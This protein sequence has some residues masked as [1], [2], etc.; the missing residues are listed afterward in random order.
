[1]N[2]KIIGMF[3]CML[4][5]ANVTAVLGAPEEK[6]TSIAKTASFVFVNPFSYEDMKYIISDTNIESG[7]PRENAGGTYDN[8]VPNPSFEEGDTMPTGWN[9]TDDPNYD[10]TH[11]WDSS[12]AHSGSKSLG[13]SIDNWYASEEW[14]TTDYI[15]V[16][17]INHTYEL[18]TWVKFLKEPPESQSA[19][20][21]LRLYDANKTGENPYFYFRMSYTNEWKFG[22][23]DTSWI[24][25]M[26]SFLQ[27]YTKYIKIG[28]CQ[29]YEN[30]GNGFDSSV[31]VRFDDVFFGYFEKNSPPTKPTK[32]SGKTEGKTGTNYD[33]S[34]SA[35]DPDN[36]LLCYNFS[37]GDGTYNQIYSNYPGVVVTVSHNWSEKGNYS[38]KVKV[39]DSVGNRTWSDW[40][41]PLTITMPYSYKPRHQFLE[42][43]FQRF[44]HAFPILRQLFGY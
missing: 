24:I 3:V 41:D 22:R 36:D 12:E 30:G 38:V 11:I 10:V 28:L 27:N 21:F 14:F 42:L 25:R 9:Y 8:L 15:P 26:F 19:I 35:T 33:Y 6:T 18:S 43:L 7:T 29:S 1:M 20:A 16:D 23:M 4:L 44:P 17:F 39:R 13:I 31:M 32:P 37:W 40:S 5:I 34:T 2:K